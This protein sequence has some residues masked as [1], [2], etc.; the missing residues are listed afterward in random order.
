HKEGDSAF[1]HSVSSRY[2]GQR[3]LAIS[4]GGNRCPKLGQGKVVLFSTS[5]EYSDS[6]RR[7]SLPNSPITSSAQCRRRLPRKRCSSR[8]SAERLRSLPWRRSRISSG[9]L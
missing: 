4:G 7:V 5:R 8:G 1:P 6:S 3:H 2:L 9:C